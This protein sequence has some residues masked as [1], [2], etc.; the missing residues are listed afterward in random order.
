VFLC[1][2]GTL[3]RSPDTH[4][5]LC[6]GYPPSGHGVELFFPDDPVVLAN[7]R[8][9]VV[10]RNAIPIYLNS[11]G[12]ADL[13]QKRNENWALTGS[14]DAAGFC[15]QEDDHPYLVIPPGGSRLLSPTDPITLSNVTRIHLNYALGC[16]PGT[17]LE[18][19][20]V[21]FQS[22]LSAEVEPL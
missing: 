10:N 16:A 12:T 19:C 9:V 8:V 7:L 22:V 6:V 3:C 21:P 11:C 14:L 15:G 20:R 13:E 2:Q 1:P 17:S 18:N 4:A 5:G